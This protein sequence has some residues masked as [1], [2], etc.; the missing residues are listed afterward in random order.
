MTLLNAQVRV[1]CVLGAL[2]AFWTL[3]TRRIF[4]GPP[5]TPWYSVHG[6]EGCGERC[7][8][9][10]PQHP[11]RVRGRGWRTLAY[12]RAN[13]LKPRTVA[14]GKA[15]YRTL[16]DEILHL[17]K[18]SNGRRCSS[19]IHV[20]HIS[21]RHPFQSCRDVKLIKTETVSVPP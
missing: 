18:L 12:R 16:S 11:P 10:A 5:P 17:W 9:R 4:S 3:L 2:P 8:Q 7:A 6:G 14:R 20:S 21:Q 1:F 15:Q 13:A 19:V